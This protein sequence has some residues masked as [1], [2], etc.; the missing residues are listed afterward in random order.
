MVVGLEPDAD[1]VLG[2]QG[3]VFSFVS[4]CPGKARAPPPM[5]ATG[6]VQ[7]VRLL[8]DLLDDAGAHGAA[9]LADGEA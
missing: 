2:D 6:P 3:S 4:C 7:L 5:G 9:A 1:L 8:E